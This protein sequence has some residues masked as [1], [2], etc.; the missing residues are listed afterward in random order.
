MNVDLAGQEEDAKNVDLKRK[1]RE[2]EGYDDD[3]FDPGMLGVKKKVLS[4]YD[5]DIEGAQDGVRCP[6]SIL[7]ARPIV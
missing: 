7:Y 1:K 6:S 3:E 4:K 5:V 2:Y